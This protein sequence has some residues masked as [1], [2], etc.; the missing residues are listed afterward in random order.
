[1][2]LRVMFVAS[3]LL[4]VACTDSTEDDIRA[5]V[6]LAVHQEGKEALNAVDHLV[7]YGRRALPTIE[8][9]LHTAP[10]DGRKTLILALRKIGDAESVPLLRQLALYDPAPD[11][12][13]EAEWTLKGWAA[14]KPGDPLTEKSREAIRAIDEIKHAEEAG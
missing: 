2:W 4:G 5:H 10:P 6:T 12:R 13:R 8:A 14:G 7:H 1:M 3:L 9:A 11:V